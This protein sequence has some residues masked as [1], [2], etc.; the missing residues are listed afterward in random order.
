M[1]VSVLVDAEGCAVGVLNGPAEWAS[2]AA[3]ALMGALAK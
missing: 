1:P 2:P 3:I